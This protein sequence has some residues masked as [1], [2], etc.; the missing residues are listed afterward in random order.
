MLN[1]HTPYIVLR[2]TSCRVGIYM[3]LQCHRTYD[4]M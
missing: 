4:I 1:A 2:N 3:S